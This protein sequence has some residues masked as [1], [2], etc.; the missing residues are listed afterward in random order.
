M[1]ELSKTLIGFENNLNDLNINLLN[2]N[3]S[4]S[5]IFYGNKGIGKT[6]FSYFLIKKIFTDKFKKIDSNLI[7]SNSHFNFRYIHRNID[8]K[9][10]N[11]ISPLLMACFH[12]HL[13]I[14]KIYNSPK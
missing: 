2:K 5:F 13:N 14:L 8:D 7:Y 6:T 11:G 10:N 12:G 1:H 9:T 4:N 3:S